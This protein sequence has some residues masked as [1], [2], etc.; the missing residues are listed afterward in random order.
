MR[1]ITLTLIIL[2]TACL[3][4]FIRRSV[5]NFHI[6]KILPFCDG[7]PV[8]PEYAIGGVIILLILLWGILRLNNSDGDDK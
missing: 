4:N 5:D 2:I 6:A 1:A 8:S 3:L 7:E